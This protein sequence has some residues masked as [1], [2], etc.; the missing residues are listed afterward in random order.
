MTSKK[1][2]LIAPLNWG[3]GHAT[4]CIPIIYKLIE[5]DFNPIIASDGEALQ[6]L[7]KEFPKLKSLA[8]PSY[9]IKFPKNGNF[10]KWKLILDTPRVL[11]T[12][13]E[14]EIF[15]DKLIKSENITGI[16]SDNRFGVRSDE[17]P[18]VFITHQLNVLSGSTTFL[19]SKIHQRFIK[20]FDECWIPDVMTENS[21]AKKL[22]HSDK[23]KNQKYIGFLSRFKK[24][25]LEKKYD[26]LILLS[27]I[28]PLRSQLENKLILE[29]KNYKGKVLFV[30][31]V[32][33]KEQKRTE[34]SNITR[35]NYLL[36]EELEIAIN[37]S[38]LVLARSGYS[39]IMDLA[40]LSKKA[41]FIPTTGQSEQEYLAKRLRNLRIAP[42]SSTNKFKIE[43]L[44][45][46]KKYVGF[47]E[48][49]SEVKAELFDLFK[50]E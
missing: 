4:R 25:E 37:Q 20:K 5:L 41:F 40:V 7:Q 32:I 16:I 29:L 50:G 27:G 33:E 49:V 30:R 43:M 18:S 21:L 36:S 6:L 2:I 8:L 9:N 19:S 47:R 45:E 34:N 22:S 39:T 38:D 17:L 28:E 14:E 42:Y 44:D 31:G 46:V 26:L 35:C 15:I 11:K 23:V 1:N 3:L 10:L 12:I 48:N 24:R 13:K